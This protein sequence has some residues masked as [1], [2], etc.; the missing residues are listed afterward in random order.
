MAHERTATHVRRQ[1]L[2]ALVIE[3]DGDVADYF[4]KLLSEAG[5]ET[6]IERSGY[7]G[8]AA[9]DATRFWAVVLDLRL[10]DIDGLHLLD[11]VHSRQ[12]EARI[13]VVSGHL[14]VGVTV[15]AIRRGASNVLEKPVYGDALVSALNSS[16]YVVDGW[17]PHRQLAA[18]GDPA[19]TRGV[20]LPSPVAQ[21]WAT[22]VHKACTAPGDVR[23]LS[24][25]AK[26]VGASETM[27]A[28]SCRMLQIK[29]HDARDLARALYAM[30]RSVHWRCSPSVLLDIADSRTLRAFEQ[31][32]GLWFQ[33]TRQVDVL[34]KFLDSQQFVKSES[35]GISALFQLLERDTAQRTDLEE[36][37]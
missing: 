1:R 18:S 33:P 22:Y 15:E 11:A 37:C 32:A 8:I 25:W 27:I 9:L 3:D 14:T 26:C 5:F 30:R 28:E 2:S 13:V 12:P 17:L 34:A 6:H 20:P 7:G 10:P 21:R 36:T 24:L 19:D 31:R 4:S 16:D 23:T 35:P 29:P